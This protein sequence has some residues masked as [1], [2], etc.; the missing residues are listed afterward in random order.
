M[1][2][3]TNQLTWRWNCHKL[4]HTPG[5]VTYWWSNRGSFT[6]W[7]QLWG[8]ISCAAVQISLHEDKIDIYWDTHQKIWILKVNLKSAAQLIRPHHWKTWKTTPIR[9]YYVKLTGVYLNLCDFYLY[10]TWYLQLQSWFELNTALAL[11]NHP[12]LTFHMLNSLECISILPLCQL[13]CTADQLIWHH[14]WICLEKL[15][16]FDL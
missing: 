9:P 10:V 7:I 12:N 11:K 16:Q 4:R 6:R 13:I 3:C 14:H 8:Q 2:N 1:C 15:P 5:N